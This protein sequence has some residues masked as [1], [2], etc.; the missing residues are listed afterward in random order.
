MIVS[1][2]VDEIEEEDEGEKCPVCQDA[3]LEGATRYYPLC[4]CRESLCFECLEK[5]I[6]SSFRCP[7]CNLDFTAETLRQ[8]EQDLRKKMLKS[9]VPKTDSLD[10]IV[11]EWA[12]ILNSLSSAME[13]ELMYMDCGDDTDNGMGD[14]LPDLFGGPLALR[15]RGMTTRSN[16]SML[17]S[18]MVA[19]D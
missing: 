12:G 1:D 18:G 13:D 15:R 5:I 9:R 6:K 2:I 19:P 8:T 17:L 7:F 4:D 11:K 14:D 10:K 16:Q 3:D